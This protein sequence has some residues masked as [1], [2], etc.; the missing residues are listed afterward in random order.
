MLMASVVVLFSTT[1]AGAT[2][3]Q[4]PVTRVDG[5]EIMEN[6]GKSVAIMDLNGDDIGDLVVGVP[7]ASAYGLKDAGAV[8]IFMSSGGIPMA[9]LVVINGT[10]TEDLFGWCVANVS[11]VNG[12]GWSDLAI[13]TPNAD[14]GGLVDAGQVSIFYGW[15]GFD[16]T[17]NITLEGESAGEKFG[18]SVAAAGD[19]MM[20]D[21]DDV[22]V[23]SPFYGSGTMVEA[24][25]VNIF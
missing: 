14:P 20:D 5:D 16:G 7:Y 3:Y 13:G 24:G 21:M 8:M 1:A 11:D 15:S 12:D 22:V 2:F 6:L 9:S 19:I 17:V 23:G 10:A 4:M 18:F 25:R